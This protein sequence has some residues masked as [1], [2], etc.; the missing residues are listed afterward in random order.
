[1]THH[2]RLTFANHEVK[3]WAYIKVKPRAAAW[4]IVSI[5]LFSSRVILLASGIMHNILYDLVQYTSLV[6]QY[7]SIS[8]HV[9]LCLILC[10][11]LR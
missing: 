10:I 4:Q 5:I 1:M 6:L 2:L 8:T 3:I 9:V 7:S 11:L